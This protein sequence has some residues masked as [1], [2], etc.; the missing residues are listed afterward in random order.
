MG[1]L[2]SKYRKALF[3]EIANNISSNTSHYYAFASNPI[4]YTGDTPATTSSVYSSMFENSWTM[5]FGKKIKSN[6]IMP[7]I[8]KNMWT[9]GTVYDRYDNNSEEMFE[10]DNFYVITV[11]LETG[12]SYEVFKCI[13]NNN[14][15]PSTV[16]PQ[17]SRPVNEVRNFITLP[18]KYEWRYITSISNALYNKFATADYIPI[19]PNPSVAQSAE[20]SSGVD[21][22][23]ITQSGNNYSVYANGIV[24]EKFSDY[25]IR[26]EDT[27]STTQNFYANSSIYFKNVNEINSQMVNVSEYVSNSSG[28]WII[29]ETP[30]D[31]NYIY[32]NSTT[33][34]ISPK[35]VFET[36]GET[37]PK[38]YS[39]VNASSNSI[40]SIVMLD[41]GSKITWANVHI[42]SNYGS[43]AQIYAIV[44]PPGGH[45]KD[46]AVELNMKG[47]CVV[48]NFDSSFLA[49]NT[50][51]NKIGILKNPSVI[52]QQ[53]AQK[54]DPFT[55]NTFSALL[56]AEVSH[57]FTPGEFVFGSTSKSRGIVAFA[58]ST[59]V[60][61]TGDKDF[62]AGQ[63]LSTEFVSN[64][65]SRNI[66]PLNITT[67]GDIYTKDII[68]LY[69]QNINN[70][71]REA[72]QTESFKII[73][74]L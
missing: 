1:K 49:S 15:A 64:S 11:P 61:L 18:D 46:P 44:A 12:G 40:S 60:F 56:K 51:Y 72:N 41:S 16:N 25:I 57:T 27:S 14:G 73:I 54:G 69:V 63:N 53:T 23:E 50:V 8:K 67:R 35:V 33:Y 71:T 36:D 59:Q 5:L 45:G 2:L 19:E 52:N 47:Y 26:I 38:A 48:F 55:A 74:K 42:E 7:V 58:N 31:R 4:E 3:D 13:N 10:R 21:V 24:R 9:P 17:P 65:S 32:T 68:P 43:G 28:K 37:Q 62:G 30:V 39:V 22:V 20:L 34:Y 70:V 6:D 29:T 66:T